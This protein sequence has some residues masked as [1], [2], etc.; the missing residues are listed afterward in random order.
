MYYNEYLICFR[1]TCR[2]LFGVEFEN[3]ITVDNVVLIKNNRKP[4][5]YWNLARLIR[6][7]PG[8]DNKVRIAEVKLG[9]GS[10]QSHSIE[11]LYPIELSLTHSASPKESN[12]LN[13]NKNSSGSNSNFSD[14]SE[15]YLANST[16]FDD[17]VSSEVTFVKPNSV[18]NN[19]SRARRD[20]TGMINLNSDYIYY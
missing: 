7:F 16:E 3:K 10:I 13:L 14:F 1:E 18:K 5:I 20:N 15:D 9:N 11:K 4:K 12:D 6:L 8:D 19:N 2:Y 17:N